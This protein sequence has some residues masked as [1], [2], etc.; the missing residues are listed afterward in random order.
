MCAGAI[1]WAGLREVVFGTSIQRLIELGWPQID[2]ESREVFG[3]AWRL[4]GRTEVVGGVLREEMD[5]WFEWQFRGGVCPDGCMRRDGGCV[6][7]E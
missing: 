7:E 3:R 4:G 6:P 2:I 1:A 5:R